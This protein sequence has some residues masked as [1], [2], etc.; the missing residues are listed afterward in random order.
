MHSIAMD[1]IHRIPPTSD[2]NVGRDR[3]GKG[4][5]RSA[6]FHVNGCWTLT[7]ENKRPITDT[8]G[9][10]FLV[11]QPLCNGLENLN[12]TFSRAGERKM[13]LVK[14]IFLVL[15]LFR[16]LVDTNSIGHETGSLLGRAERNHGLKIWS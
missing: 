7:V 13:R 2:L 10:R 4:F 5:P 1:I 8:H 12:M 6:V 3:V 14:G 15:G 16:L 9:G 11:F